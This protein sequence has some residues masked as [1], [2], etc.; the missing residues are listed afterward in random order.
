MNKRQ[1]EIVHIL[2][3]EGEVTVEHL[4]LVV[5][6]SEATI[7]RDLSLLEDSGIV[8]RTYGGAKLVPSG[9]L[10]SRTFA[11]K[12]E[13]MRHEKEFIAK[14]AVSLVKPGMSI[15]IDSGSTCW[16]FAANVADKVPL[17]VFT[18]A[19][20]V[21]EELGEIDD[22]SIFV[23]GG[24]FRLGNLDFVGHGVVSAFE[25]IRADLAFISG[26][27]VVA[28]RGLYSSEPEGMEL[29]RACL[30]A[31]RKIIV[32]ADHSKFNAYAP[33]RLLDESDID[34]IITDGKLDE[35]V[36]NIYENSSV[37]ILI[38]ENENKQELVSE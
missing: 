18:N 26:D 4:K 35:E 9:S 33:F 34:I 12:R 38:T 24:R 27:A 5:G 20:P 36:I 21:I 37:E 2:E 16:R 30:R 19:L 1:K 3:S 13:T 25:N 23:M 31:S 32:L 14:R 15:I 6:V 29:A 8:S 7:R 11:E 22:I 28:G 10:V 17:A